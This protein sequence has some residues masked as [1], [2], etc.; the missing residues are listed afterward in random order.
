[1]RTIGIG[2]ECKTDE[3]RVALLPGHVKSLTRGA[4]CYMALEDFKRAA[5]RWQKVLDE[6][7][8]HAESHMG[9]AVALDT[10]GL[11]EE[12]RAQARKAVAAD[13]RAADPKYLAKELY[14]PQP[15]AD[16]AGQLAAAAG[17]K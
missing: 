7:P 14:W 2:K 12:A 3:R 17:R 8:D 5:Q 1:M 13:A 6:H 9:L 16:A 11:N 15:L 10:Q 4:L